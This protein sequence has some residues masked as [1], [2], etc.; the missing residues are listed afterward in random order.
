MDLRRRAEELARRTGVPVDRAVALAR[1]GTLGPVAFERLVEAAVEAELRRGE[2][3][4]EEVDARRRAIEAALAELA[5]AG[6]ARD[7]ARP[8]GEADRPPPRR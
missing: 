2:C 4:P 6:E 7:D 8:E 5:A 1:A 3:G